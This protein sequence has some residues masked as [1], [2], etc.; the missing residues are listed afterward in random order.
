MVIEGRER[1]CY[2]EGVS[3]ARRVGGF[4]TTLEVGP[5]SRVATYLSKGAAGIWSWFG[6]SYAGAV[7]VAIHRSHRGQVLADQLGRSKATVLITEVE[8]AE[9]LPDLRALGFRH[10]IL[11]DQPGERLPQSLEKIAVH[12][13]STVISAREVGP[14]DSRPADLASLVFTSGSTGRSK[15]ALIPHNQLVRGGARVAEA[16]GLNQDDVCHDWAPLSHIGGQLDVVMSAI[17]AGAALAQF[18]TFSASRFWTQVREVGSTYFTGFSNVVHILLKAAESPADSENSLR[19]ALVAGTPTDLLK[20]F[21]RRFGL[22]T[23]DAY[24][25]TEAEPLVLRRADDAGAGYSLGKVNPDFEI[26]IHDDDDNPLP[27]GVRG[28]I[29]VRPRAAAVMMLGYEGDDAA[30]VEATR[31]LWLHTRD[32]GSLDADGNL[33]FSDREQ[34]AIRRRGENISSYELE[35]AT[36]SHPAIADCAAVGVPSPMGEHDVKLVIVASDKRLAPTEIRD[37][38]S[39]K[40]AHHML[41]RF[42]ELVSALPFTSLG[43]PDRAALSRTGD[44]VWDFEAQQPTTLAR[45]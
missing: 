3:L 1:I 16:F 8:A 24:G 42:I 28:R 45:R 29:V 12:D 34:N 43:K 25:M 32:L 36:R 31:N 4:L 30:T 14:P 20:E 2:G 35:L 22:K 9:H 39:A 11:V 23:V 13:W 15:A 33:H 44:D 21:E 26:A 18:K 40:V 5:G 19:L 27:I 10:V 17:V 37:F 7:H 6:T 41:P 38:L